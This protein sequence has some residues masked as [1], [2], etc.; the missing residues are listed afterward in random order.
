MDR[1]PENGRLIYLSENDISYARVISR[2]EGLTVR[3]QAVEIPDLLNALLGMVEPFELYELLMKDA[4]LV[5]EVIEPSLQH[6]SGTELTGMI[7]MILDR[8]RSTEDMGLI[9]ELFKLVAARFDLNSLSDK[10]L[11]GVMECVLRRVSSLTDDSV[12]E[13]LFLLLL[14]K[15]K[16]ASTKSPSLMRNVIRELTNIKDPQAAQFLRDAIGQIAKPV[17]TVCTPILPKGT[18][19]YQEESDGS[20]I[21]VMEREAA[22]RNVIYHKTEYKQVGHPGMLF[23][24]KIRGER[25]IGCRIVAVKDTYV[26]P[27]TKLYAYPFSN[28]Y[29][30]A[31][32][33]WPDLKSIPVTDLFQLQHLPELFFNSPANDHLFG[34]ANLRE[35]FMKLQNQDFDDTELKPLGMQVQEFYE[36]FQ[37]AVDASETTADAAGFKA[38][39]AV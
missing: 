5:Q 24:F 10:S 38:A 23:A 14:T 34:G 32:A 21:M 35:W 31:S 8:A 22:K 12:F 33:C 4:D 7:S 26:K 11:V 29:G 36:M 16:L 19:L 17:K 6:L 3:D 2:E 37:S 1:L 28:V 18:V 30:D 39:V 15:V 9:A 25:I 20:R 27:T 13:D